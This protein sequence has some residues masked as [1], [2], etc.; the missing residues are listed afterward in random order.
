VAALN[1]S[2]QPQRADDGRP[3]R[4]NLPPGTRRRVVGE[5]GG[6]FHDANRADR[7]VPAVGTV[8]VNI[9]DQVVQTRLGRFPLNRANG[10]TGL[11][12]RG[13]ESGDNAQ[14]SHP[15]SRGQVRSIVRQPMRVHA[16][17]RSA[18]PGTSWARWFRRSGPTWPILAQVGLGGLAAVDLMATHHVAGGLESDKPA[19]AALDGCGFALW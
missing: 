9:H 2:G 4:P 17:W 18:L 6:R 7:T 19:T 1:R 12:S 15:R 8:P 3:Q 13:H 5:D 16:A 10:R 11:R 14:R